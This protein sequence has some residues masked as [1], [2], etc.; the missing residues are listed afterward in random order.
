VAVTPDGTAIAF[1]GTPNGLYLRSLSE[2]D[3]K[4]VPGTE[5]YEVA[6]PVFSPDG[7]SIAFFSHADQT[8]KVI[9]VTGGAARTVCSARAVF[10]MRWDDS[11][12]LLFGQGNDGIKKVSIEGGNAEV[13]IKVDRGELAHHPQIL[14]DGDHVMFTLARGTSQL[15]W[16][17]AQVIAQSLKTGAR[18]VI[19]D[20]GSDARY[21]P[22][23]HLVYA[24][25]GALYAQP[26]DPRRLEVTGERRP[27]IEGIR[28]AAGNFTGA[29][30]FNVSSTGTLVYVPGPTDGGAS[31]LSDLALM[32]RKGVVETLGLPPGP[33]G[34]ARLSPDGTRVAFES[35]DGNEAV[36]YTYDLAAKST[37]Q[38]LTSG[39]NNRYPTWA[40]DRMVAFQ[41][42]RG[43]TRAIWWQAMD[44]QAQQL[45]TPEPGTEHAPE[46]WHADTL[47]YSATKGAD[48]SLW[49]YSPKGQQTVRV[50]AEP[51][52][53]TMGATVSPDGRWLAYAS[54]QKNLV[55][56]YVQRFPSGPRYPLAAISS[57]TPKHPRWSHDSKELC[58]DFNFSP[59]FQ[60]LPITTEPFAFGNPVLV[61][62]KVRSNPPLARTN[63]DVARDGRIVG[64]VPTGKKEY[65]TGSNTEIRIVLNWFE[66]LKAAK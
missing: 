22:S 23:G 65:V 20:G 43:G 40:S 26:F 4:V 16:D 60:C 41:S 59:F 15:R 49:T 30:V 52:T 17:R 47:L 64:F 3:A 14:P 42:D 37:M 12:G 21:L 45:T 44:G 54:T 53:A 25:S 56:L 1:S 27:V 11:D 62:R 7:R 46:S 63:Y 38:R 34:L 51:S 2:L 58:L 5:Q 57:D 39:G 19:V 35:D 55:T 50:D 18:K 61:P 66:A 29:A 31:G 6:E 48:V 10:G 33:Y 28:R 32:D 13:L 36:I 9:A 8:I 24:F